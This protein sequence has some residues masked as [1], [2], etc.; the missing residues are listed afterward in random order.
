MK[1]SR[2]AFLHVQTWEG[3]KLKAYL[4]PAGVWT[5]GFGHTGPEVK[6]ESELKS[7]A[8]AE[9][10]LLKDLEFF[11]TGVL[12]LCGERLPTQGQFDGLVSFA[13]NVG[14]Q[15]L[16]KST[17]LKK[18]RAGDTKGAAEEFLVWNKAR[19]PKTKKLE[20]LKGLTKRREAERKLF[21]S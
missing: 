17:L 2:R 12:A 19:N 14:L 16:S 13:F 1:V 4:C 18:Y 3:C 15:R 11:E 21:I 5:V 20:P 10:L 6:Q 7:I 9:A 8:E